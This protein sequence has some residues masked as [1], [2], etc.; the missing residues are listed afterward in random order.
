MMIEIT[1]IPYF[2]LSE[3]YPKIALIER[4]RYFV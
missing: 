3:F 4:G 2:I 1:I